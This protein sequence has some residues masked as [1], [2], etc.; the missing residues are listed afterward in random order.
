[1]LSEP[2]SR[3]VAQK[4]YCSFCG[5]L[6]GDYCRECVDCGAYVCVQPSPDVQDG[7][8]FYGTVNDSAR[9]LCP[10]CDAKHWRKMP[11]K[12][13]GALP[14]ETF[15]SLCFPLLT[16]TPLR[17]YG[18]RGYAT[19]THSKLTWPMV[20]V[21]ASLRTAPAQFIRDSLSLE[22]LERYAPAPQNVSY[23]LLRKAFV[24]LVQL[25]FTHLELTTNLSTAAMREQMRRVVEHIQLSINSGVPANCFVVLDTHSDTHSGQLQYAGG[26]SAPV[27]SHAHS[28]LQNFCGNAFL[29]AMQAAAK[30]AVANGRHPRVEK[31]TPASMPHNPWYNA[32]PSFRGGWRGLLM[33]SCGP[34]VTQEEGFANLMNLL[35]E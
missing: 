34:A 13:P 16:C 22:F 3:L 18:F 24:N 26:A 27:F 8:I 6:A 32:A 1:M 17:Q 25:S 5:R 31:S 20:L 19:R 35:H 7:C 23:A 15:S 11:E 10:A 12:T 33:S 29:P 30:S 21:T 2:G 28:L 9:F 4:T 14:V